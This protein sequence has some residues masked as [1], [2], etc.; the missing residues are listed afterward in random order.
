LGEGWFGSIV[1]HNR[2]HYAFRLLDCKVIFEES[3]ECF[4][5]C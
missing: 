4:V 1:I 2:E 3:F 5:R